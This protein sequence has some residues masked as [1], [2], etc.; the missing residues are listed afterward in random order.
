MATKFIPLSSG[1]TAAYRQVPEKPNPA[2]PTLVLLHSFLTTLELY[3]P[4]FNNTELTSKV[5]LLGIDEIVGSCATTL[6]M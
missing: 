1:I 5:N 2:N 4:Q 6:A 3:Q